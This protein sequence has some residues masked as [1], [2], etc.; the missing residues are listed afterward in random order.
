MQ[1]LIQD[2][3]YGLR[4]LVKNPGFT[5]VAVVTLA[6]GIGADT[7][8][9]TVVNSV[10]L[11]PLPY[12][13][14]ERLFLIGPLSDAEF[15]EFE[16]QARA[17]EHVSA[18][19]AGAATLTGAGE[20]ALVH[21]CE[22]TASFWPT[23][24][25]APELGRTFSPQEEMGT[26]RNVAVI[27]DRLWRGRF[28]AVPG[29]LGKS[30]T[31]DGTPYAVVG[32]MPAGFDFPSSGF[33]AE[34]D[35]W[36]LAVLDLLNVQ[37]ASRGVIGRLKAGIS[38]RQAQAELDV[39]CRRFAAPFPERDR[40]EILRSVSLHEDLVGGVRPSLLI[41][42]GAVGLVLLIACANVANLLLARGLARRQEMALRA[43]LGARRFRLA[44]QLLT[45]SV[46]L[47]VLGGA[48]GLLL[49]VWGVD[50]FLSLVPP[51]ELPRIREGRL[52]GWVL[53]FTA[54]L[55]FLTGL[56]FGVIPAIQLSGVH[57]NE[58]LMQASS[59]WATGS[60]HRL[61]D[62]LVVCEMAVALVLLIGAGLM[63]KSFIR[64]RSVSPGFN[65][66]DLLAMTTFP[67]R[68]RTVEQLKSF[69][70]QTLYQLATLPGISAAA[71]V[72]WLPF[73]HAQVQSSVL[74]EGWPAS[75]EWPIALRLAA[76]PGYLRTMGIRMLSGREFASHDDGKAPGVVIV[77]EAW[78][79]HVWPG[80]NPVGKRVAF[81]DQPKPQDWS[82]VVGVAED[83][84][85]HWLGE[86]TQLVLYQPYLQ[87]SKPL[88]LSQMVF[89]VR[90]RANPTVLE[91]L[92]QERLH[93]VDK[94]QPIFAQESMPGLI[95]GS[96]SE[97]RF[98]TS[99]L[100]TFSAIALIIAAIGIYG[101]TAF[102]VNQRTHEVGIRMA[103][104]AQADDILRM[105]L[106]RSVLLVCVGVGLGVCCAAAATHVLQTF[107]FEV[108]STDAATFV[109]VS[110][111]LS[112]VALV[113]SYIPA[114]RATKVDPM[115]ALRFE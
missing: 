33:S 2:L 60:G 46:L 29:I 23:L 1:T 6:L 52:D 82:T 110:L 7:A 26:A 8:I 37:L 86:P 105:V 17:F 30:V 80:Q 43:S 49:A 78:A 101:V 31:L 56:V 68:T 79:R 61:N 16:K 74:P 65:P 10:L 22:V 3:R 35:V 42:L 40:K 96:I 32:V 15:A 66:S 28:H 4:M 24:G 5:A 90:T 114:R 88:F 62:A 34:Q 58:S 106:G 99:I 92:M 20:P 71:A 91:G 95:S 27:S 12:P 84:K 103:L 94:D 75:A 69:E 113:A 36:S 83:V 9:F 45:E 48:L 100:G 11:R 109:T 41:L 50:T 89:I 57:L 81:V 21:R 77:G 73:G 115:V 87:T 59:R 67:P 108:K 44:R 51:D 13:H 85:Q 104:G 72:N 55:S 102:S 25:I 112:G 97:P 47:S 19:S 39:I 98:Y 70:Q 53:A 54:S 111:L 14:P 93:E 63:I 38:T 76:S 107:L 18:F 64:L